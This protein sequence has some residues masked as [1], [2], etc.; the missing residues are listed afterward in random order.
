MRLASL[1]DLLH[2]WWPRLAHSPLAMRL[3]KASFA[4]TPAR[5]AKIVVMGESGT[6]IAEHEAAD[7]ERM[8]HD[9]VRPRRHEGERP[10][11]RAAGGWQAS[12]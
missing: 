6:L 10:V 3:L 8:A 11:R 1:T 9:A 7:V 12:S 5:G 4:A 2:T